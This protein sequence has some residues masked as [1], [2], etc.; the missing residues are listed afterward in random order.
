MIGVR[1][2]YVGLPH[3]LVAA[4]EDAEITRGVGITVARGQHRDAP[5]HEV[6]VTGVPWHSELERVLME[7]PD[8]VCEG[9]APEGFASSWVWRSPEVAS[10]LERAS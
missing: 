3:L 10:P 4:L 8:V 1:R 6:R 5:P 7:L 9:R 2:E